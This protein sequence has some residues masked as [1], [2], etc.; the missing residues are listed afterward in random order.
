MKTRKSQSFRSEYHSIAK[1]STGNFTEVEKEYPTLRSDSVE[2]YHFLSLLTT[3]FLEHCE[4]T[5]LMSACHLQS[6]G[7]IP[8]HAWHANLYRLWKC[9]LNVV[10]RATKDSDFPSGR[11]CNVDD[12]EWNWSRAPESHHHSLSKTTRGP[13]DQRRVMG[14]DRPTLNTGPCGP[15]VP[16][17]N[18]IFE[19]E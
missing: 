3:G 12:R 10:G 15:R 8:A 6:L 9:C 17:F 1:R 18:V 5:P 11:S 13:Q 2:K 19:W 4:D 16:R 7:R 14:V